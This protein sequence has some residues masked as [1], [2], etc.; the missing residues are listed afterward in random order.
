MRTS[1]SERL[2]RLLFATAAASYT[3]NCA[4][5][6]GVATGVVH[7]GKFRWIHH[8]LYITTVSTSLVA[9]SSLLWSRNRAGLFLLPA[10]VPLAIIPRASARSNKH[11]RIAL[12][13]A[14]FFVLSVIKAWR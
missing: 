8:A 1:R 12:S 6:G 7:T 3:A 5:G 4:L 10:A 14:P 13:A 9:A 11:V 2:P